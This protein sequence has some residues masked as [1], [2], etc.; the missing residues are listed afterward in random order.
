[1]MCVLKMQ[2]GYLTYRFILIMVGYSQY[3]INIVTNMIKMYYDCS[4][5]KVLTVQTL[6]VWVAATIT[7]E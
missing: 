5:S 7:W 2:K 1:M 6:V 4:S 3:P